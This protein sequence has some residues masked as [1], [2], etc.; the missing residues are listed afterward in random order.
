MKVIVTSFFGSIGRSGYW[1]VRVVTKSLFYL[2]WAI[3]P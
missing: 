1:Q 2:T 3:N